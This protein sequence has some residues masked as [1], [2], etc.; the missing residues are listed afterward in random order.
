VN[1]PKELKL[2]RDRFARA[3]RDFTA[4]PALD[5]VTFALALLEE[6]AD[7]EDE[8]STL[9]QRL[10]ST[11]A[12]KLY[13]TVRALLQGDPGIPE[14]L[15]EHLFKML[16]AF[17]E[18]PRELPADA[19]EIKLSIAQRLIDLYLEGHSADEKAAAV[20]E[21]LRIARG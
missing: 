21:L 9:A 4:K 12:S 20:N 14:P 10:R 13:S 17:D 8:F 2:A 15:L 11:H 19:R 3:E 16:C 6:V 5:D 1:E 7:R 18:A